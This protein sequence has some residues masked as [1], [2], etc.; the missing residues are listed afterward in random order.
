MKKNLI[1]LAI[2]GS[3]SLAS[4][5]LNAQQASAPNAPNSVETDDTEK[6]TVTGSRLRRDSFSVTTPLVTVGSDA[7]EDAG[8][9]SLAS[10]LVEEIPA[11]SESTSNSN[12]QSLVSGTGLSTINLRN[13]G[14]DRTLTLIDGRR[15]VSNSYSGNYVSLST[16]PS[17]MVHKVEVISG[18]ASATYGSDA[19]AGVVNIITQQSKEGF[20]IKARGGK[21]TNG[22]GEEFTLDVN[23]GTEFDNGK[24][25]FF[26]SSTYDEQKEIDFYDRKRA[27]LET[28]FDYDDELMCNTNGTIDGD[29]CVRDITADDWRYRSD[30]T[31]GGVFVEGSGSR[32]GF[33]Y[34]EAGLQTDWNEERDGINSRQWDKIRVPEES[35]STAFKVNYDITDDVQASFQ[36]QYSNNTS[37]NVKS[38]E[39]E[40]E[41][42]V[43]LVIDPETGETSRVRS[44]RIPIDNPYVPEE[45][46]QA[47]SSDIKWDRRM[48]E[49][50]NV[51]TDNE[52]ETIRSWGG[53]QGSLFDG[54]WDWDVSVGYG[55]FTQNQTRLNEIN[56]LRLKSALDAEFAA[57]GTTVQCADEQA[58]AQG[59]VPINLFG[60][61]SITS[62]AANWIRSNPTIN[63]EVE[64][65][66]V[67][68]YIAGDLFTLPAG[69]VASVFG[70]EYRKDSQD[71]SVSDE[72]QYGGVTFNLVPAFKGDIDVKEVFAEMAF[73]LL[74]DHAFA[75]SL[76]AETSLRLA[77]YSHENIDLMKSYKLGLTWQPVEGYLLRA[78][79][80]RSQRAP[81]I[82]ELLSPPRGDYDSFN[83]ICD[84]VTATSTEEGHANCRLEP[85][86]A[87]LIAAD[88]NFEFEDDNNGYGPNAGNTQLMEET[89]DTYT[90]GITMAPDYV[91]GLQIAIDY[92]DITVEGAIEEIDNPEIINQ[93]YNSSS[94]WGAGNEFCEAITRDSEG[95]IIEIMQRLYNV[96]EL[97]TSGYDVAVA[98]QIDLEN[99]GSLSLKADMTHV[100][101]H[102]K[103]YEGNDGAET[104]NYNGE[105]DG[106]TFEDIASASITWNNDNWRVRWSTKYKGDIVDSHERVEEHLEM[107]AE[108]DARC[109]AGDPAC[110]ENPEIP[111]YLYYGSYIKHNL[112]ASYTTTWK[113]SEIRFYGG[114]NNVFDEDKFVPRTGATA[115]TGIGN[116]DS[117]YGG[118]IGRFVF[119][120]TQFSF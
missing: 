87:A 19:I 32:G 90:F 103:T 106:G 25:Y 80:A 15:V 43:V 108:N 36:I 60:E 79:Y 118:G 67:L 2:L 20:D 41:G 85:T 100:I 73:P 111:N 91:P 71:L 75:K 33:W 44:S 99:Y 16:I 42:T 117:K 30:G 38:P 12:S 93:C 110:V 116:Y 70:A 98:Y 105:L 45:I 66:N 64:Q 13:L 48:A 4:G 27:L 94:A 54:L 69:P 46:R 39:D 10:V 84:G 119:I 120:G 6:V 95:Q 55:K 34:N 113:D 47:T 11:L 53:L 31:L 35:L 8:L 28:D 89:G 49:V 22:G 86:I 62:E 77:D 24:G 107:F 78:N 101:D 18:G 88:P 68:G 1:T 5:S 3:F 50:G 115:E 9:G 63:T 23:Y 61:G 37:L 14:S 56:V 114:I 17:G 72:Q 65:L 92:Y 7:I 21:T 97:A 102:T 76:T 29:Q 51:T 52:R 82:T 83:D 26:F 112:S 96:G 74:K 58:R 81:N 40:Y 59:C 109:A 57:D 104:L